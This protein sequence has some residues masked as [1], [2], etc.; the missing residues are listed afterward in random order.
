VNSN[1][2]LNPNYNIV[3]AAYYPT[4]YAAIYPGH[5]SFHFRNPSRERVQKT[6]LA[7]PVA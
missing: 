6:K 3:G 4:S 7:K 1:I 5:R 2:V